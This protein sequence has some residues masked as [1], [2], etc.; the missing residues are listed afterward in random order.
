MENE[1]WLDVKNYEGFYQ[2]SNYGNLKSLDRYIIYPNKTKRL[3]KGKIQSKSINRN[4][5]IYY[6]IYKNCIR[7]RYLAH[8]LVYS[9]FK[10][11]YNNKLDINHIDCNK[12]NNFI[13]NLEL[14]TRSE[15][16]KHALKNNLLIKTL[17]SATKNYVFENGIKY[18]L[19]E[20]SKKYN[21]SYSC[22]LLRY[23]KDY[24]LN[25]MIN[26]KLRHKK[27]NYNGK[28]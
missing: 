26:I 1:I 7:K 12:K 11:D 20:L 10:N 21:I 2:I 16:M 17:D 25:E 3:F 13:E 5:Y 19:K 9:N 28:K 27:I 14:I 22:L 4:G 15:N 8:I 6:D 24:T 18:S 23:N